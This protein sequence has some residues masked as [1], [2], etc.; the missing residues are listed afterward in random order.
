[1]EAE[2]LLKSHTL[3]VGGPEGTSSVPLVEEDEW[4]GT[5]KDAIEPPLPP[6]ALGRLSEQSSVRSSCIDAIA[7]NT[8]G[9]GYTIQIEEDSEHEDIDWTED[10]RKT[11]AQLESMAARDLRLDKPQL[12]ELLYAVK[13][14]EEEFGQGF[15]E[16]SRSRK[17]G[18]PDGLFHLPSARMRRLTD[19]SGYLLLSVDGRED[20]AIRFY[21]FGEK[22]Q[23]AGDGHPT[24]KLEPGRRWARNE[25]IPFKLYCSE[26]RDYGLPRDVSMALEYLGDKL[27]A[28]SN[29]SFFDSSGTPPTIIFVQG[30]E[31][32]DGTRVTFKVPQETSDRI[33]ATL[34]SDAGH[35][36]RVAI[37]PVPPGTTT[38]EIQLGEISERDMGFTEFRKDNSRRVLGAFRLQ[39]IFVS[40]IEDSGRYT[41]EVQRAITLEQLF[42][43]E[44]QRYEHRLGETLLRD[45]GY[46]HLKLVFRRLAIEDDAT[47]REAANDM[48]DKGVIT[49]REFRRAH[50]LGPLP[51]AAPGVT[52]KTG[53]VE[54]GWNDELIAVPAPGGAERGG[55][56]VD[57]TGLD[58]GLGG[59]A[60]SERSDARRNRSE[61]DRL[62]ARVTSNGQA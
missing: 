2:V 32:K 27:A 18:S 45:M 59:R 55:G 10:A 57:N 40:D 14:D 42:D 6:E 51:E 12:D 5:P 38:K 9:L 52:P 60:Q 34:K 61:L 53:E 36:H 3:T 48:A 13:S 46:G 8:V 11:R 15:I 56:P 19:R 47:R 25:V 20:R 62:A 43:P 39:P 58:D 4:L 23:Y 50:G 28:Q 16:V 31:Q 30:E 44:Q 1:M 22:V 21:N 54:D 29:I 49:R 7:R 26:S 41:A 37:V 17:D 24:G 33:A 35:R